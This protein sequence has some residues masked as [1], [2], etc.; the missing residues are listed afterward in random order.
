MTEE[1]LNTE[2]DVPITAEEPMHSETAEPETA[3]AV[4][5]GA[6]A[7]SG[8][9]FVPNIVRKVAGSEF[10]Q[11]LA[12]ADPTGSAALIPYVIED[13]TE[14]GRTLKNGGT[15]KQAAKVQWDAASDYIKSIPE[16]LTSWYH[17]SYWDEI[18]E[19]AGNYLDTMGQA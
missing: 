8:T 9:H 14:F 7:S 18:V 12:A 13:Y 3:E 5:T 4:A 6:A 17:D 10:V 15:V 1:I 19:G 11:G 2:E 16:R